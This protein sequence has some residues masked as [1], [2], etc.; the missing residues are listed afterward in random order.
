MNDVVAVVTDLF[1]RSR[2]TVAAKPAQRTVRFVGSVHALDELGNVTLALVDLDARTDVLTMIRALK[3]R[4]SAQVV[5]FGPHLD[6][7]RRK[8]ARAAGADRVLAKSKF[9]AE[10]PALM[11]TRSGQYGSVERDDPRVAG[12]ASP[13]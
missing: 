6:T 3:A 4:T 2:I 9:V 8:A 5:A 10:L 12:D 13:E 11:A 1:F 7:E